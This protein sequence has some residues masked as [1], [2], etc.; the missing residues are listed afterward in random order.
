MKRL[1]AE[2]REKELTQQSLETASL[3]NDIDNI[4][5]YI[6]MFNLYSGRMNEYMS[7]SI[8]PGDLEDHL[9]LMEYVMD[10]D[11]NL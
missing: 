9:E 1:T 11:I 5:T 8:D 4:T 7:I 10:L 2:A 3:E 6:A